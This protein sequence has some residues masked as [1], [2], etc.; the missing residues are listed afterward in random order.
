MFYFELSFVRLGSFYLRKAIKVA[1]KCGNGPRVAAQA[2]SGT[3][4]CC[5]RQ[6]HSRKLVIWKSKRRNTNMKNNSRY[7]NCRNRLNHYRAGEA[8]EL[9]VFAENLITRNTCIS[10]S[11]IYRIS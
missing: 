2:G 3:G 5:Q 9:Y 7:R 1:N 10:S 6:R 4:T 8:F 11:S